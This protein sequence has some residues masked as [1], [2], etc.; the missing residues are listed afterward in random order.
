MTKHAEL[1]KHRSCNMYLIIVLRI[2]KHYI[3]SEIGKLNINCMVDMIN[4]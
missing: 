4:R 1:L 2:L 3:P